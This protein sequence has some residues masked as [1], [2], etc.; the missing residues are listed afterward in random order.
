MTNW[1]KSVTNHFLGQDVKM[2]EGFVLIVI[3]LVCKIICT[4]NQRV[5]LVGLKSSLSL[6]FFKVFEDTGDPSDEPGGETE[7]LEVVIL[8]FSEVGKCYRSGT[9]IIIAD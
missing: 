7:M 3:W 5:D 4:N 2:I 9:E 8:R 6:P 1:K